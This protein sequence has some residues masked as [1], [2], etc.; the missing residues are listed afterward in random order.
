MF[1]NIEKKYWLY[2]KNQNTNFLILIIID[3]CPVKQTRYY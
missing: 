2:D 3:G 1:A